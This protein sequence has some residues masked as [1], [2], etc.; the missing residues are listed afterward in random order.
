MLYV[1]GI[2]TALSIAG[3]CEGIQNCCRSQGMEPSVSTYPISTF[4][5]SKG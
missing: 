4:K 1:G 2:T 3:E 5:K